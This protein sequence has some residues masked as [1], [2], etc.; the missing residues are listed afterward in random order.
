MDKPYKPNMDVIDRLYNCYSSGDNIQTGMG[1]LYCRKGK[2][3]DRITNLNITVS[4]RRPSHSDMH[5][6]RVAKWLLNI[7]DDLEDSYAHIEKDG[8]V[9]YEA[10]KR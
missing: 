2:P 1:L 5:H 3:H 10:R 9:T 7:P 8:S 4:G 6:H